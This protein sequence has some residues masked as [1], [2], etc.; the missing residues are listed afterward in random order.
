MGSAHVFEAVNDRHLTDDRT[1]S[2][3]RRLKHERVTARIRDTPDAD[4]VRIHRRVP[5]KE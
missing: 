3:I 4:T 2:G 5:L 1:N